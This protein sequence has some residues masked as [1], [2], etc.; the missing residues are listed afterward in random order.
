MEDCNTVNMPADPGLQLTKS[1]ENNKT[2]HYPY[3]QLVGSLLYLAM[4]KRPDICWIVSKL[5]QF[6]DC[7]SDEHITTA[8][9]VLR[10]IKKTIDYT[11]HFKP[12]TDLLHGFSDSDWRGD[13]EDRK[14]I[15]GYIFLY[16]NSPIS[17]NS[18]KQQTVALS[19]TEAELMAITESTK[20]A[21]YLRKLFKSL[22]TDTNEQTNVFGDNLSAIAMTKPSSKQHQRSKHMEI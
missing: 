8:K 7:P 4:G 9:R 5:S 17:W 2:T 16:G 22:D 15:T 21:F 11:L 10:Y 6:L 18:R 19:S 1:S 3:R 14:S 13:Q 12:S 20:K